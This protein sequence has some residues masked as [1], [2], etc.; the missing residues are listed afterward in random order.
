MARLVVIAFLFLLRQVAGQF[1]SLNVVPRVSGVAAQDTQ[2]P[3]ELYIEFDIQTVMTGATDTLTIVASGG[4]ALFDADVTSFGTITAPTLTVVS[5]AYQLTGGG[6]PRELIITLDGNSGAAVATGTVHAISLS[7]PT[8]GA[9]VAVDTATNTFTADATGNTGGSATS[10]FTAATLGGAGGD[11]ITFWNGEKTKFWLPNKTEVALL[12][13]PHLI[14]WA[15]AMQGPSEDLQ[16]FESFK[17][18][19]P[20][21]DFV[22]KVDLDKVGNN[23]ID[24]VIGD[25]KVPMRSG[26]VQ[27]SNSPLRL[28]VSDVKLQNN[29]VHGANTTN[30]F[31]VESP[32]VSFALFPSYAGTEFP[33]DVNLQKKY[34][35]LNFLP[36]DIVGFSTFK[37]ALPQM[38]GLVPMEADTAAMLVPPSEA[39]KASE[40]TSCD[41]G[42][43]QAGLVQACM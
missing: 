30:Y 12:E 15:T 1:N 38:W 32:E 41:S 11:P 29:R 10:T 40:P 34:Q 6:S 23:Q 22:A 5:A 31:F 37:G 14:L 24:V 21:H 2:T 26:G 4:S 27:V 25:A 43:L 13:T 3:V 33:D 28:A 17:V 36:M 42:V 39:Q 18:T 20:S 9:F 8:G 35:H 19:S 16:W 7:T